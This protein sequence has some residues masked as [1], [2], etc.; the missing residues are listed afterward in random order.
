M[1]MTQVYIYDVHP[2]SIIAIFHNM[3]IDISNMYMII[4]K[5]SRQNLY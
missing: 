2:N 1:G 3:M 4:F 5:V